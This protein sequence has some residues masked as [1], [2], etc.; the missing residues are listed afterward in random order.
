MDNKAEVREFLMTRRARITPED[1][2]IASSGTRRVAGLRRSEVA[3]LA[4]LSVEYYAR[5]ERGAIGGASSSVLDALSR[6]LHLDD[7][8]HAHLLD[9]ARAADGVPTSGR[10]RRKAAR[11]A[12][13][14]ISLQWALDSI[15][16][17]VAFVRNQ[18]QDILATNE[19]GKAFY[20]P[21]IGDGGRV[22]NLARFQFLDPVSREFYP[23]W[24]LF[25]QMCVS[26]MRSEA[27]RDPHDKGLQDLVGE[28][29]TRDRT[30]RT[31]WGAH[32][33]RTH[34]AGTKRF[35]HPVVGEVHLAYEEL[36]ITADPGSILMVYT[37]EP[38]SASAER[39]RL[40][41]SWAAQQAAP[42]NA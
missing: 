14:R 40:L 28:L 42:H 29:S 8:E 21:I 17:G 27:G 3:S 31:L 20:A 33:V 41:G 24:D 23:D 1:A 34:G 16:D 35:H 38:G 10:P 9:L 13:P 26:I 36:V 5:I 37:A 4:G 12:A 25:A 15:T 32:D 30:F 11:P 39:L 19:L 22:P 7:T 6:A 2:G 18:R